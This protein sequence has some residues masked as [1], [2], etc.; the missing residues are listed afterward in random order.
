M[1]NQAALDYLVKTREA[2]YLTGTQEA[3][4][5]IKHINVSESDK[6]YGASK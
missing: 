3:K 2:K 4:K 1:N 6:G 5:N